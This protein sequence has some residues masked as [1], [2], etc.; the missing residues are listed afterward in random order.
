MTQKGLIAL[1]GPRDGQ[2]I[3]FDGAFARYEMPVYRENAFTS[4]GP[5]TVTTVR[6]ETFVYRRVK[7]RDVEFLIPERIYL[8][9]PRPDEWI[10][11]KLADGY[12]GSLFE[13]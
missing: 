12:T 6:V 4:K 13:S 1:G 10:M 3:A 9:H 5:S 8:D 11:Q 7:F 2:R